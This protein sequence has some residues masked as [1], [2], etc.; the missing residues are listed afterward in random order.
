M[1]PEIAAS[2]QTIHTQLGDDLGGVLDEQA[3]EPT[4][5]FRQ[6][7]ALEHIGGL[8]SSGAI[9]LDVGSYRFGRAPGSIMF[10]NGAPQE[11]QF[12]LTVS[13]EGTVTLHPAPNGVHIDG[14]KVSTPEAIGIGQVI[15]VG[16]DRF[17]LR[18]KERLAVSRRG[19]GEETLPP[20][21]NPAKGRAI[22]Q[23]IIDWALDVRDRQLRSRW[24][25]IAGP[26]QVHF[27]IDRGEFFGIG[28]GD[29]QFFKPLIGTTDEGYTPPAESA[30]ANKATQDALAQHANLM[31]GIPVTVDL[32]RT[33]LA[34]IGP[35]ALAK[36]VTTW[37]ALS[38]VTQSSPQDLGVSTHVT[39]DSADWSWLG[40]VP[41]SE[42]ADTASA[43]LSIHH[44]RRPVQPPA[45]GGII[46]LEPGADEPADVG[47]VL[48]L[49]ADSATFVNRLDGG[50]E[51]DIAPIGLHSAVALE[52][53]L[54]MTEHL[55][56]REAR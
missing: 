50:A 46:L 16:H 4:A 39:I 8:F 34:I 30:A 10:D 13:P 53:S 21:P 26:V 27:Q 42:T 55:E 9:Q 11:P 52:R 54:V 25:G 12:G 2:L 22:D 31:P 7:M 56:A 1:R 45:F 36:A 28:R 15:G 19:V 44:T 20:M 38:L 41:H 18:P 47:A 33:S 32:T 29:A 37:M 48:R 24:V 17:R 23:T 49:A 3:A 6:S 35:K 43:T 5:H 51:I 14:R 40:R